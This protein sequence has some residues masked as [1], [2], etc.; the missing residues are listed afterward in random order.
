MLDLGSNPNN[1]TYHVWLGKGGKQLN[2]LKAE[3]ESVRPARWKSGRI[4]GYEG[5]VS[6]VLIYKY[7]THGLK[8]LDQAREEYKRV[9][10]DITP[11]F[12]MLHFI[13]LNLYTT[14]GNLLHE[15]S[16]LSKSKVLR[17]RIREQIEKT[18]GIR[19]PYY[20][21]SYSNKSLSPRWP[22][23]SSVRL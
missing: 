18:N 16:E 20:E 2:N 14:W 23:G 11:V 19:H 9:I 22:S 21:T 8:T 17:M 4:Q 6:V 7:R 12:G 1:N 10:N 5:L 3:K 15:F 13:L